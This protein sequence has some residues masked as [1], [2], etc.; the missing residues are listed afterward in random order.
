M[1]NQIKIAAALFGIMARS[2]A[3]RPSE[4]YDTGHDKSPA[5]RRYMEMRDRHMKERNHRLNPVDLSE[6]EFYI[7]G[8]LIMAHDKRTAQKIYAIRHKDKKRKRR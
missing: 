7:K 2:R 8:E 5:D 6:R 1:N 4:F 3:Y